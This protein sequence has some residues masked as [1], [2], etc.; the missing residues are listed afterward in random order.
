[1]HLEVGPLVCAKPSTRKMRL[2]SSTN[3]RIEQSTTL[4][5]T[6]DGTY[7]CGY[8]A[9]VRQSPIAAPMLS[10]KTRAQ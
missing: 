4:S 8:T 6:I 9:L 5:R 10:Q 1:M 2:T 7:N 3:V